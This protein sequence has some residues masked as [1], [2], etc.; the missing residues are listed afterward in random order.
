MSSITECR[1][2]PEGSRNKTRCRILVKDVSGEYAF[3]RHKIG[4]KHCVKYGTLKSSV[5]KL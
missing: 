2:S 5:E 4:R 1:H 3:T